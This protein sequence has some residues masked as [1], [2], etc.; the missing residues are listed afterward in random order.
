MKTYQPTI[1]KRDF[2]T[3]P[4]ERAVLAYKDAADMA[5]YNATSGIEYMRQK[6]IQQLERMWTESHEAPYEGNF[7]DQYNGPE[8]SAERKRE[9]R[10][11]AGSK[12]VLEFVKINNIDKL[13]TW[14]M[15][16]LISHIATLLPTLV[17]GQISSADYLKKYFFTP[18]DDFMQGVYR[19]LM[20][21][22]RSSYLSTQYKGDAKNFCSLVPLILY[23]HKLHNNIP[24]SAWRRDE[25]H[26]IV[27]PSLA[28]AMTCEVPD[29]LTHEVLMQIRQKG[30]VWRSGKYEGTPRDPLSTYKLY[31]IKETEIGHL[32]ELAQTMLAQIWCAHPS[33]RTKYMVLDPTSW[34]NIPPPLISQDIFKSPTPVPPVMSSNRATT[35][36]VSSDL[37]WEL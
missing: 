30:L 16:Q 23:A 9:V 5:E 37:P 22:A 29:D 6:Q 12:A 15:P 3:V 13:W 25:I 34:D 28:A 36:S 8:L 18:G 26:M 7:S 27:N 31:G 14:M 32:P 2:R 20:L 11:E 24:Y 1:I 17:E 10:A 4:F 19:F 21:D 35:K 33:N